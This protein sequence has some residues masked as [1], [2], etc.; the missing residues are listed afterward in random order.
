VTHGR[1]PVPHLPKEDW[2]FLH[3]NTEVFYKGTVKQGGYIC[4]DES[5]EDK[6]CSNQYLL[7]VNVLDHTSYYDIDFA[8]II[9]A[10]QV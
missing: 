8:G 4:H 9:V 5:G 3:V 10:C 7:D 2:G 6:N 1:D